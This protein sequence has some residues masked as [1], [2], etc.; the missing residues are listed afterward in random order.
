MKDQSGRRA[1]TLLRRA[2]FTKLKF[3]ATLAF[4][5]AWRANASW[6]NRSQ[7]YKSILGRM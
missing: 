5:Q 6:P 7:A 4:S 2:M 3:A 1:L